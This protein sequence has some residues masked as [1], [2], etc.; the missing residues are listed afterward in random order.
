MAFLDPV[1]NPLLQPLLNLSPF[2][3]ILI[4]SFLITL[5]ITLAYK[6]FTDQNEMK[7]LKGQQ[8]EF[9][10]RMKELR[11]NPAE[12][13]KVQKEAM[14][15]NMQYMK[16][17]FK[18]TLITFIPIILI[19]GWMNA[20]LAYEPIFPDER[21]SITAQFA[22]GVTGDAELFAG[23]GVDLLSEAVQPINSYVTWN[24][25]A[26]GGR[27]QLSVKTKN[28]ERATQVL[29]TK[30][31]AYDEPVTFYEDSDITSITTNYKKMKPLGDFS[32]F[33][34][35]PG[36]LGWYI[37]F[38]ILFSIGLRKVMKVY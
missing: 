12:M 19:F 16:H 4:L 27:H 31:L 38:S 34:W 18:V 23:E 11:E 25:K 17:S 13:M 26:V 36:W 9:Q 2:W 21:F 28:D 37:L 8:K 20:H 35:K 15:A 10:K 22:D 1:L 32:L 14:Q 30:E 6:V 7:R 29:I 24:L 5:L 3:A 33:G